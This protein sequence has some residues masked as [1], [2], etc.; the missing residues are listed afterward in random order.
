MPKCPIMPGAIGVPLH[1]EAAMW[2][3]CPVVSGAKGVLLQELATQL[4]CPIVLGASTIEMSYCA[5][6][7]QQCPIAKSQRCRNVPLC[8]E[9]AVSCCTWS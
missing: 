6:T 8:W 5:W 4:T 7:H 2:L 9:P 3:M 1:W